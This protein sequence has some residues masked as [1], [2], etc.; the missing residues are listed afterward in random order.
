MVVRRSHTRARERTRNSATGAH[1]EG[2][3]TFV[4]STPPRKIGVEENIVVL[5]KR[6]WARVRVGVVARR[7][8]RIGN[9]TV[10]VGGG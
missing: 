10:R 1:A 3:L 5:T 2:S 9:L 8:V 6:C 4:F 7:L